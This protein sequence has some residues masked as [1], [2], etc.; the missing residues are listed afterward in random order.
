MTWHGVSTVAGHEFRLRIRAGR[1]R[2][3]LGIWFGLVTGFTVLVHLAV[4]ANQPH[5]D[6]KGV[7]VYGAL[8]LFVLGL[9]LLVVP[10]L[11]GQ[12]VNGD[13]ERGTL[14]TLQVTRL[15]AFEIATGKLVAAWGTALV[16]LG[17]ALPAVAYSV[18]LGGIPLG[19]VVVV[20]FVVGLLLGVVAAV[21]LCLSALLSRTTTSG[22]LSYLCV[23]AL[24]I[25]TLVA[26]GIGAAMSAER[27]T[28][29][30][31]CPTRAD[32]EQSGVPSE[33]VEREL[34]NCQ[35]STYESTRP[36]TD[37][38]WW[39]LAPNPF[40]IVA[41]AA[42]QLRPLSAA[43]KRARERAMANGVDTSDLRDSDPLGAIGRGVRDVRKPPG[44]EG[45][46]RQP[47][48]PYG[49]A[50]DVLLGAG[51]LVL[52]ARRLHAPSRTLPRGQRVA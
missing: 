33:V 3:L 47:V 28:E 37:R 2:W 40:V 11:T 17:L 19:R 26:F 23:F 20:T 4:R 32:L 44:A 30:V 31:Q 38:V 43:E 34:E 36:R 9:A 6:N 18:L 5:A 1:W 25:G 27:Y 8:V 39:L 7:V 16:F 15:S 42:P 41:D 29:Q 49:L 21:A 52:T 46:R 50:F 14:A 13:R 12:S 45:P 35:P 24:T 48:W 51:A 10:S 22:V